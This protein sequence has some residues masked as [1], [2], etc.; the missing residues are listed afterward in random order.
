MTDWQT[1]TFDVSAY[2]GKRITLILAAGDVGDSIYDTA[3]ILDE[4]SIY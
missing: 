2:Q 1:I 3:I 4:I